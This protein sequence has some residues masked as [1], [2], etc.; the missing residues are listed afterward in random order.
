VARRGGLYVLAA[1]LLASVIAGATGLVAVFGR[2]LFAPPADTFIVAGLAYAV[3]PGVPALLAVRR[4]LRNS[5]AG[6]A[7]DLGSYVSLA[8]FAALLWFL[9]FVGLYVPYDRTNAVAA[10]G[11]MAGYHALSGAIGGLVFWLLT[12]RQRTG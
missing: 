8:A 7:R 3:I 11:E 2:G 10:V 12:L 4:L 9:P 5:Q 6:T 1:A